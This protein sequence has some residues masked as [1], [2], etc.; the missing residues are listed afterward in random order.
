[1]NRI[2]SSLPSRISPSVALRVAGLALV[3]TSSLQGDPWSLSRESN[4]E[5]P[6]SQLVIRKGT[7]RVAAWNFGEGQFKPFLHVYGKNEDRLTNSGLDANGKKSG[8]FGHHRGIFI[9]WN[10]IESDLG[11]R[12]LWHMNGTTM[13]V[14][15]FTQLVTTGGHA[16]T[17]AHIVWRAGTKPDATDDLLLDERR[18]ITLGHTD[19]QETQI[20]FVTHLKPARDLT[21]GGDLQHAGVHFRAEDEVASRRD[22]TS[23]L[24]SPDVPVNQRGMKSGEWR[25]ATLFFPI[26]DHFYRCTEMTAPQNS[27]E[28]LSWR[29][30]GRFGFFGK[31]SLA[32]GESLELRFRF[33]V[34]AIDH[35]LFTKD[36]EGYRADVRESNEAAYQQF[37]NDIESERNNR[38][39][40]IQR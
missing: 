10:R 28:E 40:R 4:P 13:A 26:G 6:G 35:A 14:K 2:F 34:N 9:G 37:L 20:D 11:R 8:T 18:R 19:K 33:I 12:D 16:V 5:G 32:A 36:P 22:E 3:T 29:D 15:Q 31:K 7:D 1:M 38:V 27:F 24:W 21:L 30:Y 17:E 39:E 23:Y 25:W